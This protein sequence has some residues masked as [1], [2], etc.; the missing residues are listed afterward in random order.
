MA[1]LEY[2]GLLVAAFA[3]GAINAVAGGGSLISF[4]ALLA[5]GYAPKTANV[6]NT[7]AL[8][9]GYAGGSYNY[10]PELGR[11]RR[12]VFALLAPSV[13]GALAGS[14]ILLATPASAF[15]AIVPYLILFACL[16]MAVQDQ[17][18]AFARTHHLASRG[19]GHVP[20]LLLAATFVLAIYGAYFGA[21]LGIIMLAFLGVLLPDDIQHSNAL[22]GMLSLIINAVAVLYF[23]VF[24]PVRWA[25]AAVMA[26]GAIAGGYLGAGLARRLGRRWLRIAVIAYGLVVVAIL[27]LK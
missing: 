7:V 26:V 14:I 8:W 20:L 16:L 11:Q 21:G 5:A 18:A 9:P 17:L 6:T 10:R 1:V 15:D 22:K 13:A 23:V 4:P 3:A 19:D 12:R 2:L 25:P 27:F 24:G